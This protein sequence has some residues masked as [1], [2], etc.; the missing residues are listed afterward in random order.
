ML[1]PDDGSVLKPDDGGD[2]LSRCKEDHGVKFDG[3][4]LR[5]AHWG[6]ILRW[7]ILIPSVIRS[8]HPKKFDDLM[9]ILPQHRAVM[10]MIFIILR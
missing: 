4:C 5:I 6:V 9:M 2:S 8:T 10:M 1:R 7:V 3:K